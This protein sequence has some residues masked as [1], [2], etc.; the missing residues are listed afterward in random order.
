MTPSVHRAKRVTAAVRAV[1]AASPLLL[2]SAPPSFLCVFAL[3]LPTL[4][5]RDQTQIRFSRPRSRRRRRFAV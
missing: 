3:C 4:P 5:N 1:E 2:L